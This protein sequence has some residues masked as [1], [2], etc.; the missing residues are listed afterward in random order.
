MHRKK[1]KNKNQKN[2][3]DFCS[4]DYLVF[5]IL[6]FWNAIFLKGGIVVFL[7]ELYSV[8]VQHSYAWL[9]EGLPWGIELD[10]HVLFCVHC[11]RFKDREGK[12]PRALV[13]KEDKE[14]A[15][16]LLS[17][18]QFQVKQLKYCDWGIQI[19]LHNC[20]IV[21]YLENVCVHF[22]ANCNSMDLSMFFNVW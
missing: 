1:S 17:Q 3:L 14:L 4:L 15:Q 18:Q 9:K 20:C 22:F 11:Y 6:L 13:D 21:V 16:Y 10:E 5:E 19:N 12:T 8:H 2:I 7:L